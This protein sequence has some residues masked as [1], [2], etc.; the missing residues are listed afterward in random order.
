MTLY[1]CDCIENHG[2]GT[3]LKRLFKG[4]LIGLSAEIIEVIKATK[5]LEIL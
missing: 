3:L 2:M 1:K 5:I 4:V